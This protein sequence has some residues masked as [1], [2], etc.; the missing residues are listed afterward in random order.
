VPSSIREGEKDGGE[1]SKKKRKTS[2][3]TTKTTWSGKKRRKKPPN[4]RKKK[5]QVGLRKR[6]GGRFDYQNPR[7][8]NEKR[9]G[10]EGGGRVSG[11][12]WG[13]GEREKPKEEGGKKGK[14]NRNGPINAW[15]EREW[16]RI[17]KLGGGRKRGRKKE[18]IILG[19]TG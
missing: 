5:S 4:H 7:H 10:G 9:R 16:Y 13:G 2:N 1:G 17:G 11:S 6:R 14:T 18:R 15:D 8:W 12:I 19:H 3:A